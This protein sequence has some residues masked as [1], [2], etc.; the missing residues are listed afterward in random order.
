MAD[1]YIIH[2][3]KVKLF[4]YVIKHVAKSKVIIK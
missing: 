4:D 2:S 3:S 1:D